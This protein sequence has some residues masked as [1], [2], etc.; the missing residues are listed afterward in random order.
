M[1]ESAFAMGPVL[2][3]LAGVLS[4]II[5]RLLTEAV[6]EATFPLPSV[7]RTCLERVWW[8]LLAL[9]IRIIHV[10]SHRL[11]SLFLSE[12]LAAAHLLCS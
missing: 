12:V 7:D 5:P 3:P 10:P 1:D 11:S 2:P 9:L 8:P 4:P 6:S